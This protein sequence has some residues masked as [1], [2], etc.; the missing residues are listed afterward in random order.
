MTKCMKNLIILLISS[1][2]LTWNPIHSSSSSAHANAILSSQ[3]QSQ[4]QNNNHNAGLIESTCK[5]SDSYSLCVSTLEADGR[6]AN[7]SDA[8]QLAQILVDAVRA[9][10]EQALYSLRQQPS[11]Q[12]CSA[13]YR[14]ILDEDVP[15]AQQGLQTGNPQ[16]AGEGMADAAAAAAACQHS[17][18]SASGNKQSVLSVVSQVVRAVAQIARSIITSVL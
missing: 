13:A 15:K 9:K 5:S 4:S 1:L 18:V 14:S 7:A 3:S 16:L 17:L 10:A 11:V 6:S 2:I 8:R 12:Q